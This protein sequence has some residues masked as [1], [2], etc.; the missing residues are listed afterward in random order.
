MKISTRK[1]LKNIVATYLIFMALFYVS[2]AQA[3]LFI[4][5]IMF[6]PE[7]SDQGREWFEVC[8]SSDAEVSLDNFSFKESGKGH[9]LVLKQGDKILSKDECAIVAS[10]DI[11]FK[12]DYPNFS[13][14][15][16]DSSFSL[17]NSG[18]TLDIFLNSNLQDT[19]TYPTENVPSGYSIH[20]DGNN[21]I[22][23]FASP[24]KLSF[25]VQE[26]QGKFSKEANDNSSGYGG[27]TINNITELPIY[28]FKVAE[29]EPPQDIFIRVP[30]ILHAHAHEIVSLPVEVF[31]ARGKALKQVRIKITW[32]DF[33]GD[34][35]N[36]AKIF[37]HIY[38][39]PG[40]Y[41]VKVQA[42]QD[43]LKAEAILKV[44]AS[45]PKIELFWDYKNKIFIFKN[46]SDTNLN[47]NKWKIYS[48]GRISVL[49]EA[50]ISAKS[51]LK[52]PIE[53][54]F[55]YLYLHDE[56]FLHSPDGKIK[57]RA[58][59]VSAKEQDLSENI[60]ISTYKNTQGKLSKDKVYESG[61]V[62][63]AKG[64]DASK[65]LLSAKINTD[66]RKSYTQTSSSIIGMSV[67]NAPIKNLDKKIDFKSSSLIKDEFSVDESK[68][69]DLLRRRQFAQ[70]PIA[71]ARNE[72]IWL[73]FLLFIP[74]LVTFAYVWYL[75]KKDEF[76]D[77]E[78]EEE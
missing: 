43:T 28:K 64:K 53:N 47:L 58:K 16:Y 12:L 60:E 46:L 8:N 72:N 73:S 49:S 57:V 65:L 10:D 54:I 78:F 26:A 3:A 1:I 34:S 14:T 68:D 67:K 25:D 51:D 44:E 7:G 61:S 38:K 70:I 22:A 71:S 23:A 75:L 55:P 18:E 59:K 66:T 30:D 77:W 52:V 69:A 76:D 45:E 56:L 42:K 21:F 41:T 62:G 35:A 20:R 24:G 37:Q 2:Y 74:A 48:K 32:G 63:I 19:V 13:G 5:E 40:I 33:E 50:L 6:N 29:I 4:N 15:L 9:S 17:N 27:N 11:K 39:F 31:D 36:I